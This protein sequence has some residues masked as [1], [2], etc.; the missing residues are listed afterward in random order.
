M[1]P[2]FLFLILMLSKLNYANPKVYMEIAI[3]DKHV[4]KMVFELFADELPKTAENFRALCT[5]ELGK[6]KKTD[7]PLTFKGSLFHRVIPGFMAQG[8]D[9]T[10]HDGTGGESIYGS[11]FPD[12][13]FPFKHTKRG[14]LSM[15]NT[16]RNKNTSQFFI[17]FQP[18]PFLD[19]RHAV[20]GALIEGNDVLTQIEDQ[21]TG[22]G[23]PKQVIRIA[24]CGELPK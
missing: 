21:G 20:F 17:T 15:Y 8:G 7:F 11:P 16:R 9:I 14:L 22:S 5:G 4:G 18:A 10:R 13:W 2:K 6:S 1:N 3:G 12:E 23:M 19:G 24:D